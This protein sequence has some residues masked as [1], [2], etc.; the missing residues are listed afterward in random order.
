MPEIFIVNTILSQTYTLLYGCLILNTFLMLL[1]IFA[2]ID[3]QWVLIIA[4]QALFMILCCNF[5]FKQPLTQYFRIYAHVICVILNSLPF[6]TL[7]D[8]KCHKNM[9]YLIYLQFCCLFCVLFHLNWSVFQSSSSSSV[10]W[11]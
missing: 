1:I 4:M 3:I 8:G 2:L 11:H 7:L 9:I 5:R 10:Q 6:C